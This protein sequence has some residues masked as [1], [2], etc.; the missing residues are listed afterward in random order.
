MRSQFLATAWNGEGPV[1]IPSKQSNI[2]FHME[3]DAKPEGS[4]YEMQQTKFVSAAPHRER[5]QL[6]RSQLLLVADGRHIPVGYVALEFKLARWVVRKESEQLVNLQRGVRGF[7]QR[8][9][10]IRPFN[11]DSAH[12]FALQVAN[13]ANPLLRRRFVLPT[14]G[15]APP[16]GGPEL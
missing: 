4:I 15:K 1:S 7:L 12:P 5:R 6:D 16:E 10:N 14:G 2:N 8:G 11:L 13:G 3:P 9:D